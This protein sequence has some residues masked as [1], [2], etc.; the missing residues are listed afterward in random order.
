MAESHENDVHRIYSQLKADCKE[1]EATALEENLERENAILCAWALRFDGNKY[2]ED[3]HFDEGALMKRFFA[4]GTLDWAQPLECLAAFYLLQRWLFKWGGERLPRN[5]PDWRIFRELF[6]RTAKL[7][8]PPAY[9]GDP[10]TSP[11]EW[12]EKWDRSYRRHR[13]EHVE[14][15]RAIHEATRYFSEPLSRRP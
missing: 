9:R 3:T 15:V 1:H 11:P 6:L 4:N 5:H 7:D 8:V 14:F 10:A 12:Y 2:R 13:E